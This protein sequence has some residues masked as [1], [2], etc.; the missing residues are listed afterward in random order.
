M[1]YR[2]AYSCGNYSIIYCTKTIITYEKNYVAQ[3]EISKITYCFN[4][5]H[6]K[7]QSI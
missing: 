5:N 2:C 4:F 1:I 7:M 3:G 6:I